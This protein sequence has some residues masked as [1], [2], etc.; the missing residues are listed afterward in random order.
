MCKGCAQVPG[1]TK[2]W[3]SP[4]P[5]PCSLCAHW[6]AWEVRREQ[7][8]VPGVERC[9]VRAAGATQR[10]EARAGA[11][12]CPPASLEALPLGLPPPLLTSGLRK[13][14][15][16]SVRR[17]EICG[18]ERK[19]IR[20]R[21]K[22]ALHLM[23][24]P[25]GRPQPT[26]P[27]LHAGPLWGCPAG[28]TLGAASGLPIPA[29]PPP[30]GSA[31]RQAAIPRHPPLRTQQTMGTR[32]RNPYKHHGNV[33]AILGCSYALRQMS[34]ICNIHLGSRVMK[35]CIIRREPLA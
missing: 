5:P 19:E 1:V 27:I 24:P 33:H 15:G 30:K 4:L 10:W 13:N 9:L 26:C 32:S 7:D 31:Q 35:S 6:R 18:G 29:D 20:A 34:F 21:E 11:G 12:P 22:P 28:G 14:T 17:G 16:R 3:L 25:A 23:P 2:R 8:W